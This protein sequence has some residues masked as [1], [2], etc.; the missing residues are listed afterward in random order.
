LAPL[1]TAGTGGFDQLPVLRAAEMA[2]KRSRLAVAAVLADWNPQLTATADFDQT[3]TDIRPRR[4]RDWVAD[5]PTITEPAEPRPFD[6]RHTDATTGAL[7]LSQRSPTGSAMTLSADGSRRESNDAATGD[8]VEY[9]YH[10]DLGLTQE[11]LRGSD[12]LVNLDP[13]HDARDALNDEQDRLAEVRADRFT[14]LCRDWIARGRAAAQLE[15]A[16]ARVAQATIDRDHAQLLADQQV[17]TKSVLSRE[18]DLRQQTAGRRSAERRVAS[19]TERWRLDWDGIDAPPVDPSAYTANWQS[20]TGLVFGD[21]RR[22]KLRRRAL[23][24]LLRQIEVARDAARD[25]LT[26]GAG[27]GLR[28][29]DRD[30]STAW[31]RLTRHRDYDWGLGLTWSPRLGSSR[32]DYELRSMVLAAEAA[33]QEYQQADRD[34]RSRR[35]LLELAWQDARNTIVDAQDLL[36]ALAIERRVLAAEAEGGLIQVR[37]LLRM[38]DQYHAAEMRRLDARFDAMEAEIDLRRHLDLLP[39]PPP[40]AGEGSQP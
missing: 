6:H 40:A 10:A 36:D 30:W 32:Q 26:L 25:A 24:G 15:L 28:G 21:T 18:R 5:P 17:D 3:V 27:F 37:E 38:D 11:L 35:E 29:D 22:G 13:L 4:P 12:P 7:T 20:G 16:T 9:A 14:A 23:N 1:L 2:I 33:R 31:R 19:L 8:Q 39:V 34:W